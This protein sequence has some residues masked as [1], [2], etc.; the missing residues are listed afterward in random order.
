MMAKSGPA[1]GADEAANVVG[2][3]PLP[4]MRIEFVATVGVA[5]DQVSSMPLRMPVRRSPA[6]N[7]RTTGHGPQPN[8]GV[9]ISSAYVPLTVVR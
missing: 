4:G 2:V 6:A 3:A 5:R 7:A 8:Y 1:R 9:V